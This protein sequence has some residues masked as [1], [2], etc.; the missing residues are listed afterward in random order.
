MDQLGDGVG[1]GAI[2][3]R[4]EKALVR[5]VERAVV[6][7]QDEGREAAVAL[8]RHDLGHLDAVGLHRE[9]LIACEHVPDGVALH[10]E[11]GTEGGLKELSLP[12]HLLQ[13]RIRPE[14]QEEA[15]DR[16][17]RPTLAD[18]LQLERLERLR[19]RF[20]E[21]AGARPGQL[22]EPRH[23]NGIGFH[24]ALHGHEKRLQDCLKVAL[25]ESQVG[26]RRVGCGRGG[27]PRRGALGLDG[28][29]HDRVT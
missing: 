26:S 19:V 8:R 24:D 2:A 21:A 16:A 17:H 7:T 10:D 28:E 14:L 18:R 23:G 20:G 29:S 22:L 5:L 9:F 1:V 6:G 12:S 13:H 25:Q 3:D 4:R 11:Y 15:E 27:G